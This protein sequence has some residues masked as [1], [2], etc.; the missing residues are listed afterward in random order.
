MANSE[1]K[2]TKSKKQTLSNFEPIDR[3]LNLLCRQMK[4][5]IWERE[6]EEACMKQ[7][8][9]QAQECAPSAIST[10]KVTLDSI[11]REAMKIW[12][13]QNRA[14]LSQ[15]EMDDELE[16]IRFDCAVA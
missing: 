7:M 8:K 9:G 10:R 14:G 5:K 11:N 13:G 1:L 15:A 12:R 4:Q 2:P 6:I 16:K 3:E